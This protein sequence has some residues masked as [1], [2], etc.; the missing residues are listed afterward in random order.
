MAQ[1]EV[2]GAGDYMGADWRTGWY[3]R[4]LRIFSNLL[5]VRTSRADR[6]LVI[7]GAGHIPLLLQMA[8]NAPEFELVPALSVLGQR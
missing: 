8:Q 1:F 3:N 5:R 7:M 4:N 6:I 2:G